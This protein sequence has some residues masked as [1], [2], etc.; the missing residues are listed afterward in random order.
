MGDTTASKQVPSMAKKPQPMSNEIASQPAISKARQ[1]QPITKAVADPKTGEKLDNAQAE[2]RPDKSKKVP[3]PLFSRAKSTKTPK[4]EPKGP[5]TIEASARARKPSTPKAIKKPAPSKNIESVNDIQTTLEQDG[6]VSVQCTYLASD[7]RSTLDPTTNTF[8][9]HLKLS[10]YIPFH[11]LKSTILPTGETALLIRAEPPFPLLSLPLH[12]RTKIL[13]LLLKHSSPTIPIALKSKARI[14]CSP[15]YHGRNTLALLRT[16]RQLHT[17]ATPLVYLQPFTFPGTQ[18]ASAFLLS[19]GSNRR[20]LRS[21]RS[22]TYASTSART[23]F[24][25]LS[26]A[27]NLQRM[28]FA[29]VSSSETPG[30]A[31]QNIW[32]DAGTWLS[33]LDRKD[34]VKGLDVLRF[35][36]RAFHVREKDGKGGGYRVMCWGAAEQM[37]FL[38]GLRARMVG[39][40]DPK[41]PQ[42][43]KATGEE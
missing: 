39:K 21:L 26:E 5:Q 25:L 36:E 12:I 18:V 43:T 33:V 31:V 35:D 42:T 8:T 2:K 6:D 14:V 3:N 4:V 29:H 15:N 19:I 22:E 20:L 34:P 30:K 17:E 24:H 27:R 13:N 1:R 32:K 37:E 28:S 38:E 9:H 11:L 10:S 23:M 16:C 40:V 41:G 7:G